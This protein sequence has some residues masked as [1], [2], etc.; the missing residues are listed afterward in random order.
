MTALRFGAI[1]DETRLLL[2]GLMVMGAGALAI[3]LI[4]EHV[5]GI[6]PCV[7][8]LYQRVPYVIVALVAAAGLVLPLSPR[9]RRLVIVLC[10]LVLAAGA[11]LAFYSV[12]VEEHWWAGVAGCEGTIPTI[13]PGQDLQDLLKQPAGGLRACDEDVWRLFGVS[14]AG[15][16]VLVQAAVACA[17]IVALR[18][19]RRPGQPAARR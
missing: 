17:S 14:L 18:W 7:L 19:L 5:F 16:N 13:A 3:A 6:E 8:C 9:L 11:A 10:A 15:Y 4:G 2:A 1:G 12:G